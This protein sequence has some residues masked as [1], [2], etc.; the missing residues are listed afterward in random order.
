MAHKQQLL[1][2]LKDKL[3]KFHAATPP[4]NM[5]EIRELF[6]DF[7]GKPLSADTLMTLLAAGHDMEAVARAAGDGKGVSFDEALG[8]VLDKH[9]AKLETSSG[10]KTATDDTAAQ[11]AAASEAGAQV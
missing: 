2:A 1:D 8:A 5:E 10:P 3:E 7:A 9:I 6:S 11:E 4:A